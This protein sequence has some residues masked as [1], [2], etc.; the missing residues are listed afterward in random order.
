MEAIDFDQLSSDQIPFMIILHSGNG[1]SKILQAL[2]EYR[3]GKEAEANDLLVE[4]EKDLNVAHE[5][6]FKLVQQE[7]TGEKTELS[8]LLMHAEDHLMST[9]TMKDLVKELL[10]I[11]KMKK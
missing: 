9:L 3:E 11:F 1:R 4:A 5:I 7:A 8:L 2:R 6:H 10:E